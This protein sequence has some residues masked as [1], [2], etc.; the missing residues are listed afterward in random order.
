MNKQLKSEL[1]PEIALLQLQIND[2]RFEDAE[3]IEEHGT[4]GSNGH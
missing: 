1:D 3:E 2:E 4:H